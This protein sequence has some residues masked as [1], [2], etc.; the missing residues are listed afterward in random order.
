MFFRP[1][2]LALATLATVA[3]GSA[4]ELRDLSSVYETNDPAFFRQHRVREIRMYQQ[5][6][7]SPR[8][9]EYTLQF[10]E[11][12]Q[13]VQYQWGEGNQAQ[14]VEAA[15]NDAGGLTDLRYWEPVA[16]AAG[17]LG[18]K[19][20]TREH[21]PEPA[22]T[23]GYLDQWDAYHQEWLRVEDRTRRRWQAHDTTYVLNS[24]RPSPLAKLMRPEA[25]TRS[26]LT[27]SYQGP[28][29]T[30]R[31]DVL[32]MSNQEL[33]EVDYHYTRR[34]G[35]T[36][37]SGDLFY[38]SLLRAHGT[39]H[40]LPTTHPALDYLQDSLARRTMGQRVAEFRSTYD[41][42]GRLLKRNGLVY[43]RNAQ[44]R[45]TATLQPSTRR[46][47]GSRTVYDYLPNGLVASQKS[48]SDLG[49]T[50]VV[51]SYSYRYY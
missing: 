31:I 3:V 20:T 9:L 27:R 46:P 6:F 47:P 35:L 7:D 5:A 23:P 34:Q 2:L 30:I 50:G 8:Q 19:P 14:R 29:G 45:L 26:V 48:V 10:N 51:Y 12:G 21:L 44:G 37:E 40:R 15:Y 36:E 25:A 24:F 18:W 33:Q 49:V 32:T 13:Q 22:G 1:A 4:T 42:S 43:L 38:D 11:Q 16:T 17:Q 28:A 41:A 39:H